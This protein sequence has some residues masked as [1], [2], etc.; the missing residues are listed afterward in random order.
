MIVPG[1]VIVVAAL[2]L[3]IVLLGAMAMPGLVAMVVACDILLVVVVFLAGRMLK[4]VP[5]AVVHE[6]PVR[7]QMGRPAEMHYRVEWVGAGDC[8]AAAGV[9]GWAGGGGG[10]GGDPCGWGGDCACVIAGDATIV[11]TVG[12]SVT[13]VEIGFLGIL[14]GGGR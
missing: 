1:R 7:V 14:R 5:V 10:C 11:G 2:L 13:E 3:A 8:E 9:G 12:A 4:W 6:W